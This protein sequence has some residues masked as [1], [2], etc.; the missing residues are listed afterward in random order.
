M[1]KRNLMIVAVVVAVS[2]LTLVA[3]AGTEAYIGYETFKDVLRNKDSEI[4]A[5]SGVMTIEI[6]DNNESIVKVNGRFSGDHTEKNMNGEVSIEAGAFVKSLQLFGTDETMYVF[7]TDTNDVYVGSHSEDKNYD[8]YDG[9]NSFKGTDEFD[10]TSEALLDFLIGD[11][12]SE[13]KLVNDDDGTRDVAFELTKDEM[14][15]IINLLSSLDH[16]DRDYKNHDSDM[17][18]DAYPIFKEFKAANIELPELTDDVSIDYLYLVLDLDAIQRV[19]GMKF[20]ITAS[21]L[22]VDGNTHEVTVKGSF[23]FSEQVVTLEMPSLDG[24]NIIELPEEE[25]KNNHR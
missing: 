22:D 23:K 2:M 19:E 25:F 13:F 24:K 8:R 7:D 1:R 15:A 3:F 5:G 12:K 6:I 9:H 21:G 11:L 10:K 14:P 18:L 17:D 16:D 20:E 4:T